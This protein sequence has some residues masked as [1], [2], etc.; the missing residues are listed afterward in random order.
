[1]Q[2]GVIEQGASLLKLTDLKQFNAEI[3]A[4]AAYQSEQSG[5]TSE[6][7]KLYN[8]AG[9]YDTVVGVLARALGT[10]LAHAAAGA[11]VEARALERTAGDVLR[12]Y[13]RTNRAAGKER[14]T[15]VRLLRIREAMDA[16]D[17]GRLDVALEVT[18]FVFAVSSNHD[19]LTC[20]PDHGV[21]KPHPT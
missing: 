19:V 21:D 10:G 17:N 8:L 5:R 2:P 7:I 16:K 6:A 9:E 4:R 1:L 13:E 3:L 14:E 20:S 18:V 11:D 12:H 15:V